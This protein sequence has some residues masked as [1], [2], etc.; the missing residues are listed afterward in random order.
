LLAISAAASAASWSAERIDQLKL[1][2]DSGEYSQPSLD[3]AQKLV[4]GALALT[5][6]TI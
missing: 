6:Q 4:S 3:I 1:Q 5:D 2:V